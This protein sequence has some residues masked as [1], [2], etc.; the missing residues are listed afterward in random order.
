MNNFRQFPV[1][2]RLSIVG[3]YKWDYF[4]N[5][6]IGTTAKLNETPRVKVTKTTLNASAQLGV[7]EFA[8]IHLLW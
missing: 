6:D 5:S 4:L 2:Y 3:D 1:V 7:G 8:L